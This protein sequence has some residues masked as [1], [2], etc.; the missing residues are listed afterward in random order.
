MKEHYSKYVNDFKKMIDSLQFVSSN[1]S[2]QKQ[3][4]FM[5]AENTTESLFMALIFEQYKKLNI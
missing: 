5:I 3:P 4:S 2:K 1:E